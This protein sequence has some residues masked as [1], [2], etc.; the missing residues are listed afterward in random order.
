MKVERLILFSERNE[1]S[2]T[3]YANKIDDLLEFVNNISA[4][5]ERIERNIVPQDNQFSPQMIQDA[6]DL[7]SLD[8]NVPLVHNGT[9]LL[10][11]RFNPSNINLFGTRL[12]DLLFTKQEQ[13]SGSVEPTKP[14]IRSLDP[15][16]ID[17]IKSI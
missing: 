7:L 12:M 13:A 1:Q 5:C 17:L 10:S 8:L 14:N 3:N 6:R 15:E 16:R 4:R 2:S 9:Q 11:V